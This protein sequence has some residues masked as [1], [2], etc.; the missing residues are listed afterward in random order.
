MRDLI[1]EIDGV[2][3]EELCER[4]EVQT[5]LLPRPG[6]FLPPDEQVSHALHSAGGHAGNLLE[7]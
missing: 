4:L 7:S 1:T 2:A 5:V 3:L 6:E